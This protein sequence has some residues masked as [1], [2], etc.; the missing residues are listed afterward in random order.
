MTTVTTLWFTL[1]SEHVFDITLC[2]GPSMLPTLNE[3]G[4]VVITD[5]RR[6]T[7][8]SLSVGDVIVFRSPGDPKL[9][10]CKR[11]LGLPGDVVYVDPTI[12]DEVIRVPPG[13]MW[14]QGDNLANSTDSRTTGPVPLGLLVGRVVFKVLPLSEAG[15]ISSLAPVVIHS[16]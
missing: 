16:L 5:H 8:A 11:L 1:L 14:V 10:M 9:R 6:S 12:S 13:H 7:K 2:S 4:D 3:F 15:P